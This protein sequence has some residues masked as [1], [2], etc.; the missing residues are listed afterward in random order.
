[1]LI[2]EENGIIGL[3]IL[4]E[5]QKTEHNV[6]FVRNTNNIINAIVDPEPK[7]IITSLNVLEKQFVQN[8]IC[9][10]DDVNDLIS[11]VRGLKGAYTFVYNQ[12]TLEKFPK[13]YFTS[14]LIS[15]ISNTII[16]ETVS[17]V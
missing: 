6:I 2:V 8:G 3:D 15:F 1:M 16:K 12:N 10:A 7:I 5:L 4:L 9:L 13:P 14:D 17:R 11:E